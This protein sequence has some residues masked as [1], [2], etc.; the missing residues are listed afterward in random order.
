MISTKERKARKIMRGV[1][2]YHDELKKRHGVWLTDTAWKWLQLSAKD[3]G[4]TV[5][6]FLENWITEEINNT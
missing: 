1:L 2:G 3:S 5:G 6:E 4:T